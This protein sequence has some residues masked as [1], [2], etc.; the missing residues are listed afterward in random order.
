M[1]DCPLPL[2]GR[3]LLSKLRA[4]I[5]FTKQGSLQL[6]LL[7]TG[8]ITALTLPQEEEWR[9]F[10]TEP[11]QEIKPALA[12]RWP[13]VWAEDNPPG[14]AINQVPVLTEV[15]PRAQPIRQ[16]QYLVP[17]EVLEGIQVHLKC[18]KAFVIKVPCQSPWNTHLLPVCKPG[19]RDY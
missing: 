9:L 8:V 15:K 12:K 17:R 18:L 4:T 5:S 16:K 13:Q 3:D 11:G 1:P 6:K 10:L 14:L 2:L 7:G 19:T